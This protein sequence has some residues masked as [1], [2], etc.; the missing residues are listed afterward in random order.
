MVRDEVEVRGEVERDGH[1]IQAV[2]GEGVSRAQYTVEVVR[3]PIVADEAKDCDPQVCL[4]RVP[5][6]KAVQV[7]VR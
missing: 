1:V 5:A 4:E 7:R 6:G 3:V 2:R